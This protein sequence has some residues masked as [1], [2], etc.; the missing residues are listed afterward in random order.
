MAQFHGNLCRFRKELDVVRYLLSILWCIDFAT[1]VEF[2][3]WH[4]SSSLSKSNYWY[5]IMIFSSNEV[6]YP[7][8]AGMYRFLQILDL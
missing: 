2:V 8:H 7:S 3:E 5:K 1:D 6:D 4:K